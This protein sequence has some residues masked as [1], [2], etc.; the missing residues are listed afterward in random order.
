MK[1]SDILVILNLYIYKIQN[2]RALQPDDHVFI[3]QVN[4]LLA[5]VHVICKADC[6]RHVRPHTHVI[7]HYIL[8]R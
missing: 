3:F 5:R 4:D 2:A 7:V 8:L 1:V 6:F